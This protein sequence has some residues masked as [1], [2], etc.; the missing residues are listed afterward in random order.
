[1]ALAG[2]FSIGAGTTVSASG[3]SFGWSTNY[4]YPGAAVL[5]GP[6]T[7]D[8][9]GNSYVSYY[10]GD[11]QLELTNGVTLV[12]TG[13][14]GVSGE[15]QFGVADG[16]SA[17]IVNAAGAVFDL[18]DYVY[19][20]INT[21]GTG[22]YSFVNQGTLENTSGYSNTIDVA[23][24]DTG[25][26]SATNGNLYFDA[27]G[28]FSGQ[29]GGPYAIVFDGGTDTLTATGLID[30]GSFTLGAGTL[31]MQGG[32]IDTSSLTFASGAKVTGFGTVADLLNNG[33]IDAAG[34]LLTIDGTVYGSGSFQIEAGATLHL[35][36]ST[37]QDLTFNGPNATLQLDD[38]SG[39]TGT[40]FGFGKNDSL[41]L[42]G[43]SITSVAYNNGTLVAQLSGGGTL[44]FAAP[45]IGG[46]VQ[47]EFVS[48]GHGGTTVSLQPANV[49]AQPEITTTLGPNNSIALPDA[50]VVIG[51]PDDQETLAIANVATGTADGLNVGI[52]VTTS[53][54]YGTGSIASLPAGSSD[55]TDI[56]VGLDNTT[57]G[58]KSGTVTLNYQTDGSVSGVAA[59]LASPTISLTGNVYRYAAP[60][61]TAPSNVIL[62]VGDDGGTVTENLSVANIAPADGYTENLVAAATG[63]VTGGLSGASGTTGEVAANPGSAGPGAVAFT[64][65]VTPTPDNSPNW[66]VNLGM[67]F[68]AN[69]NF[70]VSALGFYVQPDL[71]G[72][73]TVGLYDMSGNLL[74]STVVSLSD[75]QTDGYAFHSIT[76]VALT[77]GQQYDVVAFIG[78][79]DYGYSYSTAP[80][81]NP[82]VTF[83]YG[84]YL[85]TGSLAF[86]TVHGSNYYGPNFEIAGA[87]A[88]ADTTSLNVS[89]STA[90]A[91]TI[92]GTAAVALTS[93]GTGIDNLGTTSLGTTNVP[94]TATI[95]NYATAAITGANLV[96]N[97]D[98]ALNN[99]SAA[100]PLGWT[101]DAGYA[102]NAG[103]YNQ[104]VDNPG[105]AYTGSTY[106]Q[107]GNYD[108]QGLAGI[109]QT[110][111]TIA[112]A[113]YTA[114][115]YVD[116]PPGADA[117]ANALFQASIDGTPE[118][119]L[120]G[121]AGA[122]NGWTN[123]SFTFTGTGSDTLSFA[124][125]T[126]PNE[127]HLDDV[128]VVQDITAPSVGNTYTVD[129]GTF[130]QG[131]GTVTDAL[132]V[133]NI[134]PTGAPADWLSGTLTASGDAAITD[135]GLG[136]FGT[137][138][139]GGTSPFSIE[140]STANAGVFTQTITL[141]PTD[142]N[143][144]G[145]SEGLTA[146]TI[147]ATGTVLS[148]SL[149]AQPVINGTPDDQTTLSISNVGADV[150]SA[151]VSG[152]TGNAY[153]SGSFSDL[154]TGGT[155]QIDIVA[156]VDNTSA[157]ARSG[158]V[159]LA[160]TSGATATAVLAAQTVDVSGNVY[161]L[162]DP[163]ITAPSNVYLH[164]GDDGGTATETLTIAN[165]APADG[166]SEALDAAVVGASGLGGA[167]GSVTG[168]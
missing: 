46:G 41:D 4:G 7:I 117:D 51:S 155:D 162:A 167:S 36:G 50:H 17:T 69:A 5:S 66:P 102:I 44:A 106:L 144:A 47:L 121:G 58:A 79:N 109:S 154:A 96:Q 161:R 101:T 150:L 81:T 151:S 91:G 111:T 67:V 61:V 128:S 126:N 92:S 49:T 104:V 15:V 95:D 64:T 33:T 3:V 9:S 65:S 35:T 10:Y 163:S 55:S 157:G 99:G 59:D 22:T 112:G 114:S 83:D 57:A 156:G 98:F 16:D 105:G 60:S 25:I 138:D 19:S 119:S 38:P 158:T 30:P 164:V 11:T 72:G 87:G 78:N 130:G 52:G 1:M 147:V 165:T 62:H 134:A 166:Y 42:G 148:D 34:G 23:V 136:A 85:Y 153:A 48:D 124:A 113:T 160:F 141:T 131:A 127:W 133:A 132:N 118:V 137:L 43:V 75:P 56:A 29:V 89:F 31:V 140:L 145:F 53:D 159:T 116:Y 45:S 152:T 6:G 71:T 82:D 63:A 93:D 100:Y 84:N 168:R 20:S 122:P 107:L 90:T 146:E 115:F 125:Q 88:G 73:E 97:G 37:S 108:S 143:A 2:T 129:L 120:T 32:T 8:T 86:P 27:G 77:A 123:E 40:L 12:N 54:G 74:A 14:F 13:S 103:G 80:A 28:T 26:I 24:T 139:A 76:P 135:T 21:G 149:L 18:N 110:L 94:V 68:T 39:F 70:A 142:S